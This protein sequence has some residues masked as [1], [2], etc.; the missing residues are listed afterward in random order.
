[1]CQDRF[2]CNVCLEGFECLLLL[3]SPMPFGVFACEFIQGMCNMGKSPNERMVKIAK[4][5]EGS[6]ILYFGGRWPVFDACN[7]CG[8]HACHPLFKD[9]PQVIDRQG[10]ECALLRFE[11]Q[12][13]ILCNRKNIF[14]GCY[15]IRKGSGRSD[16]NIVHIDSN[17]RSSDCVLCDDIFVNLIHHSLKGCW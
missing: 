3:L 16:G 11:V 2:A 5:Q 13:V 10:M 8:V 12:V 17:D 9:Y 14:N 4:A 7:F 15:M 1:M 6:D